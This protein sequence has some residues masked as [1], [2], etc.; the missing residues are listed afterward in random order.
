MHINE[1]FNY[2]P[3]K[4]RS[5][6]P[7]LGG[8]WHE[9][10][11]NDSK[12][13]NTW[14]DDY[15]DINLAVHC[16]KSSIVV[17]DVDLR[18]DGLKKWQE[19]VN[20]KEDQLNTYTVKTGSGGYH[21]YFRADETLK[22]RGNA[23]GFID[24]KYN[25]YVV[26]AGSTHASGNK[27][28]VLNDQ[29][30]IEIPDFLKKLLIKTSDH[31]RMPARSESLSNDY[32]MSLL[33]ELRE[34]ETSYDEWV[35]IGMALHHNDPSPIGLKQ[36]H[37]FTDG[38]SY[39]FED[40]IL[41]EKKWVSFKR[42]SSPITFGT[43]IYLARKKGVDIPKL[44]SEHDKELF[45]KNRWNPYFAQS[46][47]TGNFIADNFSDA[48]NGI[49]E[50]GWLF[51]RD[52]KTTAYCRIDESKKVGP[53]NIS[54]YTHD[55]FSRILAPYKATYESGETAKV[56]KASQVWLESGNKSQ[57]DAIVFIPEGKEKD[58]KLNLFK[59]FSIEKPA[60]GS[61]EQILKVIKE[62]LCNNEEKLSE[63]LLDWLAHL[64]QQGWQKSSLIPVFITNPGAEKVF[65][66][67]KS[68]EKFLGTTS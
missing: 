38:A 12:V 68:C 28:E 9:V 66:L 64:L 46:T 5:K 36:Y 18:N 48:V 31:Q 54:K 21:Y 26:A 3:L 2:I 62:S 47:T 30:I 53:L 41:A 44:Q 34:K 6:E 61:H 58:N 27:Y 67:T 32:V 39:D 65:F 7:L 19:L 55:V 17:V 56:K 50:L 10:A 13:I 22:Y 25:G 35:K 45:K 24:V 59:G 14:L 16:K 20:G 15:H 11:S 37:Y 23:L 42:N 51:I 43:L 4:P 49:N 8:N 52:L 33:S 57:Y 40:E 60:N 63:W 29:D 1:K